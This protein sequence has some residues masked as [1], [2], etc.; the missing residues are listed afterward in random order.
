MMK[1]TPPIR[2]GK[3]TETTMECII[4]TGAMNTLVPLYYAEVAG[5][6]LNLTMPVV[7][8]G[9]KY[10]TQAYYFKDVQLGG[11]KIKRL[12]A[13]AAD[14]K[15]VIARAILL[16]TAVVFNWKVTELSGNSPVICFEEDIYVGVADKKFPYM[17][18]VDTTD[19]VFKYA[20]LTDSADEE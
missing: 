15:G 1:F 17:Q 5:T 18:Y 10:H 6:P 20:A 16:G 14:Y 7:V 9:H 11:L 2:F 13:F 4:D 19:R 3:N 12:I 8:G